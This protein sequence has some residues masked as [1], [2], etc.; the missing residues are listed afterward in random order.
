MI[1]TSFRYC[2][3]IRLETLAKTRESPSLSRFLEICTS[4]WQH[5][6]VVELGLFSDSEVGMYIT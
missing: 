1:V 4:R 5:S 3:Y 6:A 2:M